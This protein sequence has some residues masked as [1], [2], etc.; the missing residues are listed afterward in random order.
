MIK[1]SPIKMPR[2]GGYAPM[3]RLIYATVGLVT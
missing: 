3:P 1:T 2:G